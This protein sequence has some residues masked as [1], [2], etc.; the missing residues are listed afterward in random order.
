MKGGV[1]LYLLFAFVLQ[2]SVSLGIDKYLPHTF[3]T[4]LC[5]TPLCAYTRVYSVTLL[6]L[7]ILVFSNI[8]NKNAAEKKKKRMQ[9]NS[10]VDQWLGL[11][12]FIAGALVR[13][14]V[15]GH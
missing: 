13:S 2:F 7:N 1:H 14:L 8:L 9:Q 12:A 3:F 11:H 5:D 6:C 15:W 10:L 4:Q